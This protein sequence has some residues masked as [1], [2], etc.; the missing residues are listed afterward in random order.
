MADRPTIGFLGTNT[1]LA[2]ERWSAA[3]VERLQ[4]LGWTEGHTERFAELATELVRIKV[5]VIVTLGAAVT[6]AK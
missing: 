5:D 1:P 3:F 2:Q 4:E 6:A